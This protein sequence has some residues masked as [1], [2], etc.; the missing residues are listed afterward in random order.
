MK[1]DK[2]SEFSELTIEVFVASS[3]EYVTRLLFS[4]LTMNSCR[5]YTGCTSASCF[6][7]FIYTLKVHSLVKRPELKPVVFLPAHLVRAV[8]PLGA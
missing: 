8:Y 1:Q 7:L 2:G 6:F 4:G 3:A 5:S